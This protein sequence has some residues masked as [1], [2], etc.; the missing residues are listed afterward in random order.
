M[1][2]I[3]IEYLLRLHDS[4]ALNPLNDACIGETQRMAEVRWKGTAYDSWTALAVANH[5]RREIIS[6]LFSINGTGV[7]IPSLRMWNF[8]RPSCRLKN[9]GQF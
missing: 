5:R 3:L 6:T 2:N 9:F 7:G 1:E 8:K 4:W